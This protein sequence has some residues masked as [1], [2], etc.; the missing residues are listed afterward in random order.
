[1]VVITP[2]NASTQWSLKQVTK[3]LSRFYHLIALHSKNINGS[4]RVENMTKSKTSQPV[5]GTGEGKLAEEL[6]VKN[7]KT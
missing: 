3:I 6:Y 2:W 4:N 5:R 1:M 7:R